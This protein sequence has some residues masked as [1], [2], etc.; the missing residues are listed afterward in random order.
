MASNIVLTGFMGTGKTSVGKLVA[1]KTGM[2]FADTDALIEALEGKR[3]EDIFREKGEKYFRSLEEKVISRV[4]DLKGF[5][6]ATGGGAVLSADN[7][8]N[9]R[10]RG[11]I[12]CLRA[13]PETV[14]RNI[15]NSPDERPLLKEK[16]MLLQINK[17]M[18]ERE[19]YYRNA[20]YIII[21]DGR[22][23]EETAEE[24]ISIFKA[25]HQ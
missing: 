1:R 14:Y 13:K 11:I 15:R 2:G 23:A 7:M 4:S 17:L 19:K 16:D 5:V 21:V 3:V 24:V 12:F 20:H 9:L 18:E 6:I 25:I 8:D 22:T 10:K